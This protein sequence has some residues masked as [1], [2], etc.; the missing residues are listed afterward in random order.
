MPPEIP[1]EERLSTEKELQTM[2]A[3]AYTVVG[4]CPK[5]LI[6]GPF[7]ALEEGRKGGIEDVE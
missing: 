7:Y 3:C 2:S 6:L 4:E 5:A 1:A